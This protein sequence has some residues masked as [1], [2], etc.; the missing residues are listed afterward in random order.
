MKTMYFIKVG[1]KAVVGF[2]KYNGVNLV[3]AVIDRKGKTD[4]QIEQSFSQRFAAQNAYHDVKGDNLR[5]NFVWLDYDKVI[6]SNQPV[7]PI[8]PVPKSK[9]KLYEIKKQDTGFL[10]V[11]HDQELLDEDEVK[12][13]LFAKSANE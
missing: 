7:L 6:E 2:A 4:R 8:P 5:W 9:P 13:A 1:D 3:S 11:K 12:L 10:V